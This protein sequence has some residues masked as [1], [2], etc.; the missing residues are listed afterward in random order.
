[1]F[2]GATP[3]VGLGWKPPPR[4]QRPKAA[5]RLVLEVS[6][7]W[8]S[9]SSR[10]LWGWR[11]SACAD[12]GTLPLPT[13][14]ELRMR[15]TRGFSRPSTARSAPRS[16][17]HLPSTVNPFAGT[18]GTMDQFH[19]TGVKGACGCVGV[20]VCVCVCVC[21][22]VGVCVRPPSRPSCVRV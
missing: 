15:A 2:G 22:C 7:G 3:L 6:A 17:T 19:G 21:G 1:V 16:Q 10:G 5:A 14:V 18:P 8:V 4:K 20:W 12:A 11:R 13:Q 9:P